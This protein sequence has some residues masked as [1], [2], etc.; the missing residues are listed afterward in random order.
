MLAG[1]EKE[2]KEFLAKK[3]KLVKEVIEGRTAG[4]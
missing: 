1:K 3:E 4:K 2:E